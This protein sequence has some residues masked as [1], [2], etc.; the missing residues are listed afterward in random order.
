[1]IPPAIECFLLCPNTKSDNKI[2]HKVLNRIKTSQKVQM[3]VTTLESSS[4]LESE[5]SK[6]I[7]GQTRRT[8]VRE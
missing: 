2:C 3:R 5:P 6:V 4:E 1:M 7:G 8:D